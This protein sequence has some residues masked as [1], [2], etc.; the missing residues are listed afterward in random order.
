MIPGTT[1]NTM[2]SFSHLRSSNSKRKKPLKKDKKKAVNYTT[3]R[4]QIPSF[5]RTVEMTNPIKILKYPTV[6]VDNWTDSSQSGSMI[7]FGHLNASKKNSNSK[8]I[9]YSTTKSSKESKIILLGKDIKPGPQKLSKVKKPEAVTKCEIDLSKT[10][11]PSKSPKVASEEW[12]KEYTSVKEE[13]KTVSSS[14]SKST[15]GRCSKTDRGDC[16]PML[17]GKALKLYMNTKLTIFENSEILDFKEIYFVGNTDKKVNASKADT[18]NYGFDDERGDYKI[19]INDHIAFRYEILEVLGQGSF[20]Q[21]VKVI[22]HKYKKELAL[23]IIRNKK[24]FEYQAKVEIKVLKEIKDKDV[25]DKSNIIKLISSFE[26]RKH[27]CLTFELYSI[28]LYELIRSND[29]NGFSLDI[30]RRF[31]IQ[32]LQGLRFLK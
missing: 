18:N 16:F 23:K 9:N 10:S 27:I 5:E 6:Q 29:Y 15:D 22:D 24:K 19:V 28:N 30:I 26:F 7:V 17:P 21:V 25:K 32:I 12:G 11:N 8:S 1:K 31:A 14:K 20:G 3:I 13:N 4:K 2:D